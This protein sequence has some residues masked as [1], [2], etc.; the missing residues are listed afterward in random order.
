MKYVHPLLNGTVDAIGGHYLISREVLF[1]DKDERI[2]YFIG[3]A[4]TDRACCG[5]GGCGYAIVAGKVIDYLSGTSEDGRNVSEITPVP[6]SRFEELTHML[7]SREG[8]TQV[9]FLTRKNDYKS[10]F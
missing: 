4:I 8:V 10:M 1:Y 5:S 7:K 3:H 6:E 9:H 2:L